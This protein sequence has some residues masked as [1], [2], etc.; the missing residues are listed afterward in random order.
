[1]VVIM[2]VLVRVSYIPTFSFSFVVV[3]GGTMLYKFSLFNTINKF[4]LKI[5]KYL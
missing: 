1:M 2:Y 4:K 3:G 5:K